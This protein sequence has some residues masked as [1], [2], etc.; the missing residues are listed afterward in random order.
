MKFE[1]Q[2]MFLGMEPKQLPDNRTIYF[3][4]MFS[5]SDSSPVQVYVMDDNKALLERLAST[6]CGQVINAQFRLRQK[7]KLYKLSLVG[8]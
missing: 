4:S 7:D 8:V 6:K 2:V 1:K 5:P 3:V